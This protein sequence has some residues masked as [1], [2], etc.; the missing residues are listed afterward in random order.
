MAS[1]DKSLETQ[2]ARTAQV[3]VKIGG[4]C[5][6]ITVLF[7]PV[8]QV[9][10][11]QLPVKKSAAAIISVGTVE[12]NFRSAGRPCNRLRAKAV[13]VI[14]A[15]TCLVVIGPVVVGLKGIHA[16]LVEQIGGA[17]IISNY[18]HNVVLKPCSAVQDSYKYSAGPCARHRER[19]TW[20][21][22]TNNRSQSR[23]C[24]ARLLLHSLKSIKML[25]QP[26]ASAAV[27]TQA[28]HVNRKSL[29]WIHRYKK[30]DALS[31]INARR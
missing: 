31:F 8:D 24:R 26:A 12:G 2:Q 4:I 30:C 14:K 23:I 7:Q 5:D 9:E 27:P 13:V 21:P 10:V 19:E 3:C 18:K 1:R 29:R 6:V 22:G 17:G 15:L 25:H 16:Q 28:I 20:V 11:P